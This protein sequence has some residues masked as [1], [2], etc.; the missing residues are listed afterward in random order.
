MRIYGK[1]KAIGTVDGGAY[2]EIAYTE[3]REDGTVKQIGTEDFS[4]ERWS[5]MP[6]RF[7]YT[8]DG[9]RRNKGGYRWFDYDGAYRTDDPKAFKKYITS[10]WNKFGIETVDVRTR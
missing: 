8:W 2:L 10:W 7:V 6:M 9:Q 1:A 3:Y 5:K 4:A